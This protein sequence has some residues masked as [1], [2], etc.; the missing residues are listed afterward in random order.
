MPRRA[1]AHPLLL[2]APARW[3]G[4]EGAFSL[5][6]SLPIVLTPEASDADFASARALAA[7]VRRS[8][9]FALA[10]ETHARRDGLGRHLLL[11]RRGDEGQG[12]SLEVSP[13]G[14]EAVGEGPAGL[15]YAVETL[16]QLVD[17]RGRIPACAIEDAPDFPLR[18]IMLDV[19]RGKVPTPET[20]RELVE[21]CVR[22][23]LNVLMLYTEHTFQFRRHPE[24]GAGSSALEAETLRDLDR[25]AAERMVELVPCLQSLGHMERVLSL[26]AYA[27]LAETPMGWTISPAEPG[28]YALLRDLYDEFLPN[29]RSRLFNANCDEPW[30]LPRGR[31][32]A[33]ARELGPGGVY[34]EHVRRVRDL[35]AAHGKRTMIWGDV[36]HAH[37]ERIAEIDRDLFLLDWWYEAG[38]DYER[39]AAFAKSG[40]DFAV[41]P[42]TSS[43]NSLF[44]RV[45]N[46]RVN[47]ERWA[48]AGRRHGAR[49]LIVT[50]WGDFGHYNLQGNSWYAY[51][52]AAQQA[53]SGGA[54]A[55]GFER[56]FSRVLFGDRSGQTARLYREL[57]A[58]HDPGFTIF[59]GSALQYLFFD[60]LERGF[61]LSQA[62]PAALA[63]CERRLEA[64]RR[65]L[66]AARD[67]FGSDVRT[68][69]ELVYA[70][71]ASLLAVRKARATLE[72][73][74]W[75]RAPER[76]R[77]GARR[78]LARALRS[79][80]EEQSRL[81]RR[82]RRL[83]LARS[84]PS[85]FE[86]TRRRIARSASS[87]RAA[88][89]RLERNR[90]SPPPSPHPGF[91]PGA[92]LEAVRA[93]LSAAAARP[94]RTP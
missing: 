26:P 8:T 83:W 3:R 50:D 85:D 15:R 33:R 87:L 10:V 86:T 31:S 90:P 14:I 74:R 39:V 52:W 59:N 6:P 73:H 9:G 62:K 37:P 75:R 48:E 41:C 61:F 81:A 30:D 79:L 11:R 94:P 22:L 72:Y 7:A 64:V 60:E 92:V 25:F 16:S 32:A 69:A 65:R 55:G 91:S 17:A 77:A 35:A 66:D 19:S 46:G 76:L 20:L 67:R 43:W 40:I 24:I 12:Y 49:G 4:R 38:F 71:D 13:D 68:W 70:A 44:P 36:V 45:E 53:W 80:A 42:G 34:L 84:R 89:T 18:G 57:G 58:V 5:A 47:I 27:R 29:F 2:P 1:A 21:L 63:R 93:S 54:G 78:R 82:L 51:A 23:K 88:A 56:S 28:T